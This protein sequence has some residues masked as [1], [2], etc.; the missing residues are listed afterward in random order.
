MKKSLKITLIV[1]GALVVLLIAALLIL[2]KPIAKAVYA[3]YFGIRYES[4]EPLE[5]KLE[6]FDGL[7]RDKYTFS[8]NKGQILTGYKYYKGADEF[9]GLVVLAHGF[10][11]G[12]QRNYMDI[13]DYFASNGYAVFAYDVTGNDE[14]EGEAVNGLPQGVIDL[15]Y[16]LRFVK[17]HEDFKNMPIVLW[18]H[19]WGG[20]SVGSVLKLHPDVK[21]AVMV[22]G[23]NESLDMLEYQGREIA[24]DAIDIM[25]PLLRDYEA[26]TFG[27]YASMSAL[28][29]I[30]AT[31]AK[32]MILHSADDT[33]IPIEGSYDRFYERY[34]G[35]ER[36]TF[37]RFEDKGHDKIVNSKAAFE[38]QEEYNKAAQEYTDSVGKDNITEEMRAAY[39]REHLDKH[40]AYELDEAV[41]AQML[42]LYDN[43]IG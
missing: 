13:A 15:D 32:V 14:S 10:G 25:L 42:A 8:S 39:Y 35:D 21:A 36:F 41:M 1:V 5:W 7:M 9:K 20:Y 4:Y 22:A 26:D 16:A 34:S 2:P 30:G 43:S 24:G 19:S 33:T 17:S 40:K 31:D 11:G 23:F 18:G 12:G 37:I 3:Q 29:G 6:D 28:E 38:Y 27:E